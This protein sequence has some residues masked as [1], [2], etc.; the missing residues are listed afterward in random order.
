LPDTVPLSRLTAM[1]LV[2]L[3]ELAIDDV[4][5]PPLAAAALP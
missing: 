4:A 2:E 3:K 5:V 1:A